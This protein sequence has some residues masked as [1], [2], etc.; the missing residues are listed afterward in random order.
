MQKWPLTPPYRL[1]VYQSLGIWAISDLKSYLWWSPDFSSTTL[2]SI[3]VFGSIHQQGQFTNNNLTK[4]DQVLLCCPGRVTLKL[5][6]VWVERTAVTSTHSHY[7]HFNGFFQ[8]VLSFVVEE[9]SRNKQTN[10]SLKYFEILLTS[11]FEPLL[12]I[13]PDCKVVDT[14]HKQIRALD[15]ETPMLKKHL[16]IFA[17]V[18][19]FWDKL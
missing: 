14:M 6:L 19:I 4:V 8:T 18:Q 7:C 17:R 11:F 3:R 15:Q 1:N 5:L 16:W 12:K 13:P 9:S 10:S 2:F